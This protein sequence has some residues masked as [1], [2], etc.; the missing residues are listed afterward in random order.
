MER[1]HWMDF[2]RFVAIILVVFTHAHETVVYGDTSIKSIFYTID[3]MAVPLFLFISGRL[4]LPNLHN[5]PILSFYKKRLPQFLLLIVFYSIATSSVKYLTDGY[6]IYDAI[7]KS[8]IENNGITNNNTYPGSYGYARQMWYMYMII[9]IYMMAPFISRMVVN[10]KTSHLYV[11]IVICLLLNQFK[12]TSH[13]LGQDLDL[14]ARLG[15]D[16][17]GPFLS[18]F[19]AGYVISNRELPRITNNNLFCLILLFVPCA[20]LYYIDVNNGSVNWSLHWYPRSLPLFISSIGLCLIIKNTCRNINISF[21][22]N[23]SAC[24]FGIF[25]IHYAFI[26]IA[27]YCFKLFDDKLSKE[28]LLVSVTIFPLLFSWALVNLMMKFRVTRKLV[29]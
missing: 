4:I 18:Y 6:G 10:T 26:Y 11:F 2:A 14:L 29:S 13:Y 17:T 23:I 1:I 20:L 21:I 27:I 25:L 7:F 12:T 5:K 8:I 28:P 24:S 19:V 9:Q 3:R 22:N 16:Y 15:T